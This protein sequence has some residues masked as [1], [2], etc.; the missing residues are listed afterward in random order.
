MILIYTKQKTARL[1]Y[2][3]KFLLSEILQVDYEFTTD[4]DAFALSHQAKICYA[5][6]P[7]GESFFIKAHDLLFQEDIIARH[8]DVGEV[9]KTKVLFPNNE[10]DILFD[11]FAAAFYLISRYEEYLPFY[12]DIHGRFEAHLSIAAEHV[13]LREPVVDQWAFILRDRLKRKYPHLHFKERQ[14]K[15]IPTVDVDNAYAFLYKGVVRTVGATFRSLFKRDFDDNVQRFK[16]LKSEEKDPFDTYDLYEELHEK[17]HVQPIWFFLVGDYGPYDKN[18]R[19]EKEAFQELIKKIAADNK[20]GIHPSYESNKSFVTLKNEFRFLEG[21]TG[22]SI[23]RSRQH[24]LKLQLAITYRKLI[25]L[26]VEED[27]TM[28]Y[29][30]D[31]GFRAG[32]CTPFHFYDLYHE[33]E[34]KLKI[35]PFQ[36]M[37]IA[38]NQYLR[39]SVDEAIEI[40]KVL[41]DRVRKVNG[42]FISLWHNESLSDHGYW[43]GWKPVYHEMLKAIYE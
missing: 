39:L 5:D 13:F 24:Y 41:V 33:R 23:K 36:V 18:V 1:E 35:Y 8:I 4:E 40:I 30:S 22:K 37:D 43:K 38:L 42:T 16:T 32:T 17:Y 21:L 10:G 20:I 9:Q 15:F 6:E 31:A 28:G 34:T 19:K 11:P 25:E 27:Y 26:G 3:A 2:I 29:A 7:L 14:F 12:P